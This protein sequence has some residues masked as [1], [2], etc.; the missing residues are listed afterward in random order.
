M[1]TSQSRL[2][3]TIS[4]GFIRTNDP[5][6]D[7]KWMQNLD[8]VTVADVKRVAKQYLL[9]QPPRTFALI[10]LRSDHHRGV[11]G[12]MWVLCGFSWE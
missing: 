3:N 4:F 7:L 11:W 1:I 2:A 10:S 6:F 5:A 12:F 8:G 9:D